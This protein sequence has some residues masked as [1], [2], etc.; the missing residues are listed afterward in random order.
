MGQ[1]SGAN[2]GL[3]AHLILFTRRETWLLGSIVMSDMVARV[4]KLRQSS[5]RLANNQVPDKE[6]C[7]CEGISFCDLSCG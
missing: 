5:H 1:R 4:V 6:G 2:H 7:A 3:A